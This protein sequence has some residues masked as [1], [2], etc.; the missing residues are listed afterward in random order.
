MK[1]DTERKITIE[2]LIRLKKAERPPAEFWARF[3]S[4]IRAKQ[5]SAIVSR[6]PWWDGISRAF[7][8]VNRHQL[9]FG[10]AAALALTFAGFRYVGGHSESVDAP[11]PL[12]VQA[13]V[14]GPAVSR[15]VQVVETPARPQEEAAL[16]SRD[17]SPA[18]EEVVA[19]VS[20]ISQAPAAKAPESAP[21]S[22]FAD[23]FAVNLADFHEPAPAYASQSAFGTDR[24]FEPASV[25]SRQPVSEPLAR[26]DP[27]AERRARLLAPALPAYASGGQRTVA[28][29]WMKERS[30]S[31]DRMYESMDHESNNQLLVGF[32]F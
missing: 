8:V 16:A 1:R 32:R 25:S 19:T 15:P 29:D 5:L 22:P 24:D 9:P 26:M 27:S 10:A 17:T 14:S 13:V 11:R 6:R 21:R 23:G 4:E 3:E 18:P 12:A 2:D 30:S 31:D 20:H 28:A 7:A